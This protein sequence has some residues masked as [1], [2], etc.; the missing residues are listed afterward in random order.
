MSLV[1]PLI[2][3][4]LDNKYWG[5]AVAM[6]TFLQNRLPTRTKGKTP[7]QLWFSRIPDLTNLK[8]F[9]CEAYAH[10][11]KEKT[12]NLDKKAKRLIF[13]GYSEESKAYRLLDKSTNKIIISRDVVLLDEKAS[14][15]QAGKSIPLIMSEELIHKDN[16]INDTEE[17][18]VNS[19]KGQHTRKDQGI[20]ENQEDIHEDHQ[21]VIHE[22]HQEIIHED[23]GQEIQRDN[24]TEEIPQA[25]R[26]ARTNK[27][28]PPELF[29]A[30]VKLT[31]EEPKTRKQALSGPNKMQWIEAMDEEMKSLLDN[32]TWEILPAPKDRDIVSNKW[33]FKVKRNAKGQVDTFKARLVAR[34][35][36]QKYG[37]DYDQVF[38]PVMR[39]TTFRAVTDKLNMAVKHYDAKT[40]FLNGK[41][42]ETVFMKQ[43]ERYEIRGKENMV[44]RLIKSIYGLKQAARVW[45]ERLHEVLEELGF[46]RSE[47]DPCLYVKII[48]EM[49]MYIIVYV[50]DL[51]ITGTLREIESTAKDLNKYFKLSDLE[52]LKHYLGIQVEREG[53]VFSIFQEQ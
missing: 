40:A 47:A 19:S 5:E 31:I 46:A 23:Q 28:V 12:I 16:E 3:A 22:D 45:N 27:G 26:S 34:G 44:C 52:D 24:V 17:V 37:T 8:Q 38:A 50:D 1:T 11:L 32:K 6:A 48:A 33:V 18:F 51:V 4:G 9:G 7:Y 21:E 39:Q 14:S 20:R 42:K 43:P 49:I 53:H 36:S 30:S 29:V 2:D 13:T 35:F 10:I 25:R 15:S 41:L